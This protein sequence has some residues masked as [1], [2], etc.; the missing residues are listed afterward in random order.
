MSKQGI[1]LG[2][3]KSRWPRGKGQ[4]G[5][6]DRL[7]ARAPSPHRGRCWL[8]PALGSGHGK[9]RDAEE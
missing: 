1:K 6:V 5:A 9:E 8:D 3:P 2:R 7:A 4:P